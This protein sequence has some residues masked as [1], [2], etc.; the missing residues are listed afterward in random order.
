MEVNYQEVINF[1]TQLMYVTAPIA[2]VFVI[3]G[4][5]TNAVISFVRG[6]KVVRL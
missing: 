4:N 2:I 1:I 3:C 6:D 5:I